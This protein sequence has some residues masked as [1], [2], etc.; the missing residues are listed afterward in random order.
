MGRAPKNQVNHVEAAVKHLLE[1]LKPL[2][3]AFDEAVT[4]LDAPV[5]PSAPES[6]PTGGLKFLLGT[7]C[8]TL[9]DQYDGP[10]RQVGLRTFYS[11]KARYDNSQAT[12]EKLIDDNKGN[13]QALGENPQMISATT[14]LP[15]N[16]ARANAYRQMRDVF[17]ALYEEVVGKKFEPS[18][19]VQVTNTRSFVIT[20]EKTEATKKRLEAF[21]A[22]RAA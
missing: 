11:A 1:I 8:Q 14:W 4:F 7:Y 12:I 5:D 13:E 10:V 19:R 22:R 15:V 2:P 16:E 18:A 6:D 20:D 21:K 9:N 17:F 3:V